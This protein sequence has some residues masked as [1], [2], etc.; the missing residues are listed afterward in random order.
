MTIKLILLKYYNVFN[1]NILK[2]INIVIFYKN[3]KKEK[4]IDI[5]KLE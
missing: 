2:I 3:N 5:L 4:L 1:I